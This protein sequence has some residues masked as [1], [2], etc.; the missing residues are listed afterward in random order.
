MQDSP[1]AYT[2]LRVPRAKAAKAAK[3]ARGGDSPA[4]AQ[5]GGAGAGD[6]SL[7]VHPPLGVDAGRAAPENGGVPKPGAVVT[8][9]VRHEYDPFLVAS[10]LTKGQM[11]FGPS[12]AQAALE[13]YVFLFLGVVLVFPAL[14]FVV[15]PA[16]RGCVVA[17]CP[18]QPDA[19]ARC[20]HGHERR[21]RGGSGRANRYARVAVEEEE[22][23]EEVEEEE[24]ANDRTIA[25]AC[26][27]RA[28]L[29]FE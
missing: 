22:E 16:V 20:G 3:A 24:D 13:G 7:G 28:S 4:A 15:A 17:C 29:T 26:M 2:N 8:V 18:P 10:R 5:G 21:G 23:E 19:S 9:T 14:A 27:M 6:P 1:F 11:T 25:L 12:P